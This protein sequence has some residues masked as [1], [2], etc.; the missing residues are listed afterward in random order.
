[1]N[2]H[3]IRVLYLRE[4]RS[5]LRDRTIVVAG[6][7]VPVILYPFILWLVFTGFT[8]VSGQTADLKSRVMARNLAV[9]APALLQKL[10]TNPDIELKTVTDPNL[11]IRNGRLDALADFLPPESSST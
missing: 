5:A 4:M 8:F 2:L 3:D 7:L 1:M 9:T 10:Q 6:I 11:E